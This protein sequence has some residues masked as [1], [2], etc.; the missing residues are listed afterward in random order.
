MGHESR[1]EPWLPLTTVLLVSFRADWLRREEA[2]KTAEKENRNRWTASIRADGAAG[3]NT[4]SLIPSGWKQEKLQRRGRC[5]FLTSPRPW[6]AGAICGNG[7]CYMFDRSANRLANAR[8]KSIGE[9]T[10]K[11]LGF[12]GFIILS[13]PS[14]RYRVG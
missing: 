9:F 1:I 4:P 6:A 8:R 14:G 7:I 13:R 5:F 11:T 2:M 10:M 12:N 3:Q